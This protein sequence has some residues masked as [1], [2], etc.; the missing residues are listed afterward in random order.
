M[1]ISD[2]QLIIIAAFLPITGELSC[3]QETG[4]IR[5]AAECSDDNE[6][7]LIQRKGDHR[8]RVVNGP[9]R[10]PIPAP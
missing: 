8:S 3:E 10:V 1:A 6:E 2:S 7:A 5:A 4:L 9:M